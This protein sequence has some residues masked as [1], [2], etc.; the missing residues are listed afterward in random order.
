MKLA[1]AVR[2]PPPIRKAKG[3]YVARVVGKH[4]ELVGTT[5]EALKIKMSTEAWANREEHVTGRE[6]DLRA[7]LDGGNRRMMHID[8]AKV[9]V[10]G[11]VVVV[12]VVVGDAT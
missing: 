10:F 6:R 12:V 3:E 11:R 4:G 2:P 7:M 1:L 8:L 9:S 5:P